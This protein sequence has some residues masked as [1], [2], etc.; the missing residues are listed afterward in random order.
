MSKKILN[1]ALQ[2]AGETKKV[3]SLTVRVLEYDHEGKIV[4]ATGTTVP[5]DGLSGYAK[6][7]TFIETDATGNVNRHVNEGSA[8]SSAFNQVDS[9]ETV[10][11]TPDDADGV[12]V[13]VVPAGVSRV[14]VGAN[15]NNANDWITLPTLA[16]VPNG[17]TITVVSNAAG[18]EVRTP[19]SSGQEINSEDCDG[20]KEYLS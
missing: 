8:T 10:T 14:S 5:T 2:I 7:A 11:L 1:R 18:H 17:F 9:G 19:A 13:N 6:G 20:T 4:R 12:G 15:V 3:G 16:T